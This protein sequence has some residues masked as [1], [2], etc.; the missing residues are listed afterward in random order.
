MSKLMSKNY[1]RVVNEETVIKN[2]YVDGKRN[3][4]Y[5]DP[6][7][8]S[9]ELYKDLNLIFLEDLNINNS[10]INSVKIIKTKS[11]NYEITLQ[12]YN[13]S[14]RLASD[15]IGPSHYWGK[16]SGMSN[17]EIENML[18]ISRMIGGHI[19]F[20]KGKKYWKVRETIN[21]VRGGEPYYDRFDL[22]LWALKEYYNII[23][24]D[25]SALYTVKK[26]EKI[27][28][29][30]GIVNYQEYFNLFLDSNGKN[31]FANFIKFNKLEDWVIE[32]NGEY[33]IYDLVKSD[34]ISENKNYQFL[35]NDSF[36]G[37][38]K[39]SKEIYM[40]YINNT[41]KLIKSRTDKLLK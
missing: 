13:E 35:N 16:K 26:L 20:P 2:I 3:K 5:R 23:E 7:I 17:E 34:L 21:Q 40:K 32:D 18:D 41:N 6:D 24:S 11:N 27:Q 33:K 4:K 25:L 12:I 9:E 31:G 38:E 29:Y 28:I 8:V 30:Y 19:L 14:F 39:N 15:Y 37:F 10:K 22:T 36:N 1:L